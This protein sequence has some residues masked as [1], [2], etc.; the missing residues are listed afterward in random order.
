MSDFA[1]DG[2][3][4]ALFCNSIVSSPMQTDQLA[5]DGPYISTRPANVISFTSPKQKAIQLQ[6]NR[7]SEYHRPLICPAAD[8]RGQRS[9]EPQPDR[10][11]AA[12][13][14]A[15]FLQ[16]RLHDGFVNAAGVYAHA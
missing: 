1:L 14:V 5:L 4:A 8:R 9:P 6:L 12:V 11:I 2:F 15:G 13:N 3:K 10:T 7:Y 16:H